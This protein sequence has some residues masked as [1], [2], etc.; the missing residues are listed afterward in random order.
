MIKNIFAIKNKI[1]SV[2]SLIKVDS[3]GNVLEI[4]VGKISDK[5]VYKILEN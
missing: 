3:F 5:E 4:L 1:Y 2:P